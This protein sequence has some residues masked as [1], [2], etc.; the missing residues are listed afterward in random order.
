[1]LFLRALDIARLRCYKHTIFCHREGFMKNVQE[2]TSRIHGQL[3]IGLVGALVVMSVVVLSGEELKHVPPAAPSFTV[4][5][6]FTGADGGF[7]N[8]GLFRDAA[9][10]LYGTA[11]V[12][13]AGVVFKLSPTGTYTVL[14][15]FTGGADGA[16]P[17]GPL[18]RD[19]AGNL[20]GTTNQGGPGTPPACGPVM[21]S[22]GVVFKL[23]PTNTETVLHNFA[24]VPDGAYPSAGLVRDAGG[25]LYGTTPFGGS[26]NSSCKVGTNDYTTCGTVFKI[27]AKGTET[28]LY[29]FRSGTDG[30]EPYAGLIQ[31]GTGNLYGTANRGGESNL[32]VCSNAF[33]RD[34]TCGVVFKLS[35][36]GS[37][38]V[39]HTFT[40]ADG[41]NPYA[42][43]IQ[44]AAGNLYGTTANGGAKSDTCVNQNLTSTCGVVFKLIRCNSGY[45]FKVL[46]SFTGGAEGGN[47]QGGLLRDSAGNLYGTTTH[48]GATNTCDPPSGCGVVFKLSPTGTET[49]LH[50][51]TG[52]DGMFPYAGLIQDTAGNLYGT[53]LMG[54]RTS[55]CNPTNGCGVVFRLTP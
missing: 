37:E 47:P 24:G 46:Y 54:G 13:S 10:N 11:G 35:A 50:S 53:T 32:D 26:A 29:S 39:L 38:T 28:V 14:Y 4:L 48:G 45:D 7:P 51:F 31:D 33:D 12:V 17:N 5:Y 2:A 52:A 16:G 6:S 3:L 18:I 23:S 42:G 34:T 55:T 43:L 40:G 36:I 25:N 19:P 15:R 27:S 9:G 49:V 20:Y 41:A 30:G 44:D 21:P 8:A 1:M 22:C